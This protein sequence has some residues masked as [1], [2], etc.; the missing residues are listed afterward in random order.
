MLE[1]IIN[2]GSD[3]VN[4]CE[5]VIESARRLV[6]SGSLDDQ[7]ALEVYREAERLMEAMFAVS[8]AVG[9]LRQRFAQRPETAQ[10]LP[11]YTTIQ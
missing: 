2:A 10:A 6:F 7:E 4:R 8:D 5:R 3:V 11:S 9:L 1:A